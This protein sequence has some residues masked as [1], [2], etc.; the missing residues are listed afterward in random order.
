MLYKY[1][2]FFLIIHIFLALFNYCFLDIIYKK[3]NNFLYHL[4]LNIS[5]SKVCSSTISECEDD[6][7][8]EKLKQNLK[9][10]M[11]IYFSATYN[12][13]LYI[14]E[15]AQY[16]N[17]ILKIRNL[18]CTQEEFDEFKFELYYLSGKIRFRQKQLWKLFLPTNFV[19]NLVNILLAST[20]QT[21]K[22]F[23]AESVTEK[24]KFITTIINASIILISI[25]KLIP[26]TTP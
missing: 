22:I 20:F 8:K 17:V 7:E 14:G 9:K 11:N 12:Y 25:W 10:K 16:K 3:I 18:N 15:M 6:W 21:E 4:N 26:L 19:F 2:Y 13:N 23:F 1:F 5:F 24:T